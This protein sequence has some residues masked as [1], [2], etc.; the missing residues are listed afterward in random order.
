METFLG[1][2]KQSSLGILLL[3]TGAVF[4]FLKYLAPLVSPVLA[5]MLFLT[6]FGSLLQKMQKLRIHRQVGAVALLL[7]ALAAA[8]IVFG[9]LWHCFWKEWPVMAMQAE[10]WR[11]GLPDWAGEWVDR[12][13]RE[14]WR[15][16]AELERGM[17]GGVLRYAGKAA[18]LG[19]YLATFLIA[20][21]LLAKDYDEMMNR[22]LDREDCHLLLSV[23][24]GVIRYVAVYVKAQFVI[25]S[26]IAGLC[27]IGLCL[28]GTSQGVFLGF[29]AGALDALPFIGTGIVLMPLAIVEFLG[30]RTV[31]ALACVG[32]YVTC[33][34]LRETMEPKLIGKRIGVRPIWILISLYV[35]IRLFGVAGIIK[36]PLGF[37]ILWELKRQSEQSA[38][39]EM[40][41]VK[42]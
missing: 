8:G 14:L 7:A 21:I 35:G 26:M 39:R 38:A 41:V 20:V 4:L 22:L 10:S 17:M 36:G 1:K 5:A 19:G 32:L 23:I 6:I 40:T 24:C 31:A 25:M 28:A 15:Y 16:A 12:I 37:I 30:G 29:L 9:V 33:I 42:E 18:A 2:M 13:A 34:L 11:N 27:A 3:E